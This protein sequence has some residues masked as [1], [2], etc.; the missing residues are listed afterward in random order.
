MIKE[1]G[2]CDF[3]L[4]IKPLLHINHNFICEKNKLSYEVLIKTIFTV[5]A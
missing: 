2:L 1:V 3:Y 5:S 4:Y